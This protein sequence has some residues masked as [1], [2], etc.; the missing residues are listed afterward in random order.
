MVGPSRQKRAKYACKRAL[1]NGNTPR[2]RDDIRRAVW[3][4]SKESAFNVCKAACCGEMEIQQPSK[5]QVYV[6]DFGGTNRL[7]QAA[8][9]R[10]VRFREC[11]R[12]VEAQRCPLAAT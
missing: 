11:Q 7:V 1:A 8:K 4:A 12:R 9:R 6:G 10:E 5:G 3:C 2:Q